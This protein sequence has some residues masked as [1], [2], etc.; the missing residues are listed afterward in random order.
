MTGA[1]IWIA[2]C[3]DETDTGCGDSTF[4]TLIEQEECS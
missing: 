4:P 1:D 2:V 3:S